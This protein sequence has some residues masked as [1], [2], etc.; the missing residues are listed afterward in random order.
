MAVGL[1]GID[2]KEVWEEDER[3]VLW[4]RVSRG[5]EPAEE[6]TRAERPGGLCTSEQEKDLVKFFFFAFLPSFFFFLS[7]QSFFQFFSKCRIWEKIL[8]YNAF[9]DYCFTPTSF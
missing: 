3:G 7:L 1:W 4:P 8:Q 9:L 5:V 2:R 6:S